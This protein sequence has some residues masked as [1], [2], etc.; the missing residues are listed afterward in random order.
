MV[1]I[2]QQTN[3]NNLKNQLFFA[4]SINLFTS[5][6]QGHL[7]G[8]GAKS[9]GLVLKSVYANMNKI[10]HRVNELCPISV[11]IW[12]QKQQKITVQMSKRLLLG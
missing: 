7:M 4:Q 5:I 1:K 9:Y 2:M 3:K 8:G 12:Q 6:G 11:F 10:R